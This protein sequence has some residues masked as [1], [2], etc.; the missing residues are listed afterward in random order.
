MSS[1]PKLVNRG[2]NPKTK[3]RI[4][5][6]WGVP[7]TY[8]CDACYS[9]HT[10]QRAPQPV[11]TSP[12]E[13]TEF[14][15]CETCQSYLW[16][17][18][19]DDWHRYG[20]E[21]KEWRRYIDLDGYMFPKPVKQPIPPAPLKTRI[22]RRSLM[23]DFCYYCLEPGL[24]NEPGTELAGFIYT[25]Q[26]IEDEE[27]WGGAQRETATIFV[28]YPDDPNLQL[29]L[30]ALVNEDLSHLEPGQ[31]FEIK[32]VPR[33]MGV[34]QYWPLGKREVSIEHQRLHSAV[35]APEPVLVPDEPAEP[36]LGVPQAVQ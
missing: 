30:A 28:F 4:P 20:P 32:D 17:Y 36:A 35:T 25:R 26:F 33:G 19:D 34:G 24:N 16:A 7:Y 14:F 3:R 27:L 9:T 10:E 6:I 22:A 18:I 21:F 23:A 1:Q 31:E 5:F 29:R 8:R 11:D 12:W 2:T 13:R 15:E